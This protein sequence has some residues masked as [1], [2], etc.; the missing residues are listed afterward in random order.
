LHCVVYTGDARHEAPSI[1]HFSFLE[2][3]VVEVLET[4]EGL[5]IAFLVCII[6]PYT[7]EPGGVGPDKSRFRSR[8]SRRHRRRHRSGGDGS[9]ILLN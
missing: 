9:S 2:Q 3:G 5:Y 1:Y 8:L 4:S 7:S 6:I